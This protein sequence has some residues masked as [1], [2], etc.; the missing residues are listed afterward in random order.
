MDPAEHRAGF[1]AIVGR[2][3]A[4]K[5]T[6]MNRMVGERVAITT[7]KPQTTRDRIRGIR[8]FDGWQAVFVDTPGVHE[9][10]SELH[11][12]MVELAIGTIGDCDL[13]H[14]LVDAADMKRRADRAVSEVRRSSPRT[15][16][17]IA[18]CASWPPRRS[19]SSS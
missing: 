10:R 14:L 16:S 18:R 6:L 1:V 2:P 4:G 19:G 12:Y 5:S 13:V 8:T 9:A 11:R 3:N 15:T 17:P 7:P